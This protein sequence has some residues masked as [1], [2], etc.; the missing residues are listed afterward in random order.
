MITKAIIPTAGWGT[1]RLP[2]TKA[3]EKSILPIGN[4]PAIDFIVQD[5]IKA[6]IT[7][8]YFVVSGA[9]QQLKTYYGHYAELEAYLNKK[10]KTDMLEAI[11]PPK[12]IAFHYITQDIT[13]DRYGTTIAAWLCRPF[14]KEGEQVLI[15]MGDNVFHRTD[16]GSN[17]ADLIKLVQN[18]G[19]RAGL[20]GTPVPKSEVV[21]YGIIEKDAR[22]NYVRIVEKPATPDQAPSNL[23][24]ASFYLVDSTMFEYFERDLKRPQTG[25][26]MIIDPI[27]QYVADGHQLKVGVAAGQYFDIGDL[28]SWLR[29]NQVMGSQA[30]S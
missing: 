25:E 18:S 4:V 30:Y 26:Y 16:G 2:I 9:A 24:N 1:R 20:L 11:A 5:V 14:V 21:K 22:D 12:G 29:A 15:I 23:N 27:N 7:E 19:C 17:A 6:G 8:I 28:D 13:G 10:N 3:I